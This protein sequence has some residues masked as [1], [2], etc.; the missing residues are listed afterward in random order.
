MGILLKKNGLKKKV[1]TGFSWKSLLF[2]CF[3]PLFIGDT[4][5]A[6]VQ[7]A[8]SW[9]T[10]GISLFI[11]PFSYNKRHIKRLINQGYTPSNNESDR[12][13]RH[14]IGYSID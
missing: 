14:N 10:G 7:F 6:F 13:L 8:L 5:A 12:W 4:K 1:K 2:G 11:V 3:Y 9:C